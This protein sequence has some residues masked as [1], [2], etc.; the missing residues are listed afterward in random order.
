M[1]NEILIA[2]VRWR[3]DDHDCKSHTMLYDSDSSR[4]CTGASSRVALRLCVH[5]CLAMVEDDSHQ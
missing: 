4:G 1:L 3:R 5:P 2:K